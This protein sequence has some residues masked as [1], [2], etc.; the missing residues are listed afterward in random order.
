MRKT[1]AACRHS[2]TRPSEVTTARV[3]GAPVSC[4]VPG[5]QVGTVG[6]ECMCRQHWDALPW[7]LRNDAG[8]GWRAPAEPSPGWLRDALAYFGSPVSV[9]A[10]QALSPE[11]R[12]FHPDALRILATHEWSRPDYSKC[13]GGQHPCPWVSCPNHLYVT[14]TESGTLQFDHPGKDVDELEET[15]VHD[16]VR[17]HP[18]GVS[19]SRAGALAGVKR[20]RVDQMVRKL[21]RIGRARGLAPS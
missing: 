16:V 19:S 3:R 9:H 12:R 8:A 21:R 4:A 11:E 17:K 1:T 5:C 7:A 13:G 18:G 14:V 2:E 10:G 15:C 6:D 20:G